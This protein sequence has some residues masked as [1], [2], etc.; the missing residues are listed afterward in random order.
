MGA[1]SSTTASAKCTALTYKLVRVS[2]VVWTHA[3]AGESFA[4][5]GE[6]IL[7]DL[8]Y[9]LAA[10]VWAVFGSAATFY[11]VAAKAME[12]ANTVDTQGKVHAPQHLPR[13]R[14]GA[15]AT[16][17]QSTL[18][19][20]SHSLTILSLARHKA[21]LSARLQVC[22]VCPRCGAERPQSQTVPEVEIV[23]EIPTPEIPTPASHVPLE[24]PFDLLMLGDENTPTTPPLAPMP[25]PTYHVARLAM[26]DL[27]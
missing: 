26:Y 15:C 27:D 17:P 12:P 14:A 5:G 21:A 20:C 9:P 23:V 7:K 4:L 18:A 11:F 24:I 16:R 6:H 1:M 13:A 2:S 3:L 22:E 10:H 19:P 25:S 8:D